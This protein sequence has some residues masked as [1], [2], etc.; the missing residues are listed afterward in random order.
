[1]WNASAQTISL[2]LTGCLI[3]HNVIPQNIVSDQGT[4][5]AAKVRWWVHVHGAHW[6]S[7]IPTN[8]KQLLEGPFEDL[9]H[10]IGGNTLL[11][12]NK[13]CQMLYSL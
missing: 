4:H 7:H 3:Y 10:H 5:V 2:E 13:V 12:R 6:S 1:M 9:Q 8:L 11:A